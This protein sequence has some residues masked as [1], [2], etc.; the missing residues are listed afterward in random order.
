M[1][2]RLFRLVKLHLVTIVSTAPQP[3][4]VDRRRS[5]GRVLFRDRDR[6]PDILDLTDGRL[7]Q[8]AENE[9]SCAIPCPL[10]LSLEQA[11]SG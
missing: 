5:G 8:D 10:H 9:E 6:N 7:E 2:G 3:R 11:R 1:L 4:E